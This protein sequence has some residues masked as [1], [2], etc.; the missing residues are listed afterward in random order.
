MNVFYLK[1]RDTL[2]VLAVT[3]YNPDKT[4]HDLTGATSVLL[5]IRLASGGRITRAM[6]IDSPPTLGTIR[7]QWQ[8]SDWGAGGLT[9]GAHLMEYEVR[10]VGDARLTFPN[11]TSHS[12]V[13]TA[14]IGQGA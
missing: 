1:Y 6:Q 2:P 9:T 10:G 12:L 13:V 14:D 3:L 7:Y 8:A 11:H 4:I 5:S